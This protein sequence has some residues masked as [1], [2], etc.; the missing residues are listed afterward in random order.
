MR[1]VEQP[2]GSERAVPDVQSFLP[3]LTFPALRF[4]STKM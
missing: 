1:G 4:C 3:S 2:E